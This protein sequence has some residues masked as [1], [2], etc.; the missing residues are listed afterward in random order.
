MEEVLVRQGLKEWRSLHHHHHHHPP[1]PS[2]PLILFLPVS[3]ISLPALPFC[4]SFL[5]PLL[6]AGRE[7]FHR[8]GNAVGGE[9]IIIF[10]SP[11]FAHPCGRKLRSQ[12]FAAGLETHY[13]NAADGEFVLRKQQFSTRGRGLSAGAADPINTYTYGDTVAER[14]ARSPPTKVNRAQSP[15]GSPDFRKW[16]SCRTISLVGT[17]SLGSPVSPTLSFQRHSIFTSITLIGSQDPA[18]KSRQNLF[19]H[20]HKRGMLFR[21]SETGKDSAIEYR[22]EPSQ[23]QP[24]VISGNHRT[25]KSGRPDRNDFTVHVE[26]SGLI[27]AQCET[28]ACSATSSCT[29]RGGFKLVRGREEGGAQWAF[30]SSFQNPHIAMKLS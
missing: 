22:K 19:T 5:S 24:G 14:L 17:F 3:S 16:E 2:A 30:P 18:V 21:K 6:L 25:P 1:P 15:V 26:Q 29:C 23:N 27:T 12:I 13:D 20:S 10:F 28:T 11:S 7:T 8:L 9:K 4:S